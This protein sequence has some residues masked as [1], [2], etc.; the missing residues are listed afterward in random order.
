MTIN[1]KCIST[2]LMYKHGTDNA[3]R[4]LRYAFMFQKFFSLTPVR[5]IMARRLHQSLSV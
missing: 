1:D 5:R 2:S 3:H 4:W